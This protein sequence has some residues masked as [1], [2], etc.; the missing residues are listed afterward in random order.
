[1]IARI[2]RELALLRDGNQ[3]AELLDEGRQ[4]VLYRAVPT[5]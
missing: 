5:V 1:M 3:V 4:L 2:Q